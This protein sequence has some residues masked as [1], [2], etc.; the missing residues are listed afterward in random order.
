MIIKTK[1]DIGKEVFWVGY[2]GDWCQG[3]ICGVLFIDGR[4]LYLME[5]CTIKKRTY[6]VYVE[7]KDVYASKE[8][9]LNSL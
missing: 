7:E 3:K 1:F 8:E 2:G 6:A 4:V 9:L 5:E